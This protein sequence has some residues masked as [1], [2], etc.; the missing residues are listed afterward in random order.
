MLNVKIAANDL[1]AL[2]IKEY[3]YHSVYLDESQQEFIRLCVQNVDFDVKIF[4][5]FWIIFFTRI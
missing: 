1:A 2:I 5:Y 3:A 4:S